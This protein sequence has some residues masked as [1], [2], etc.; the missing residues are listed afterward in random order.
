MFLFYGFRKFLKGGRRIRTCPICHQKF[1]N[2]SHHAKKHEDI[3]KENFLYDSKAKAD[4][5]GQYSKYSGF[6]CH[7]CKRTILNIKDHFKRVHPTADCSDIKS[8]ELTSVNKSFDNIL[9]SYEHALVTT[10]VAKRNPFSKNI[11]QSYIKQVTS[12][13]QTPNDISFPTLVYERLQQVA[14]KSGADSTKYA[15]LA[16]LQNFLQFVE[17]RFSSFLPD[18]VDTLKR[19]VNEWLQRQRKKKEKRSCFVK[20]QSRKRLDGLPFPRKAIEVYKEKYGQDVE[21]LLKTPAGL[22][23]KTD[24]E[25]AYARVFVQTIS[26]I[27]CRPGVLAGFT[28][29]ELAAAEITESGMYS[30]L[31]DKQKELRKHAC[32]VFTDD[33]FS[34]VKQVSNHAWSFLKKLPANDDAVFPNLTGGGKH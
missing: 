4:G 13:V 2:V 31:I 28:C 18:A 22:L 25:S 26:N 19:H 27:G 9:K 10:G 12:L 6:Q 8:M 32:M 21:K 1:V 3:P 23:S 15:I 24:I 14:T 20:E 17:L 7:L 34:E 30:V 33:E 29:G 11:A 16:T 5:Y